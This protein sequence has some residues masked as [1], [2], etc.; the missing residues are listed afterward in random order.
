MLIETHCH[1]DYLKAEPLEDLL[2]KAQQSQI[3]KIITIGVAPENLDTARD[4]ALKYEQVYYTQ[5]IHPHDAKDATEVEFG[6]IAIRSL[7][8][9]MVAI[10]EIGT[11]YHY[12]NSPAD[13]QRKVF[14]KQLQLAVIMIYPS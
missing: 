2:L 9:K 10:G 6:K 5:G 3:T 8:K 14:E 4:I 11:D 1:L 12:N 7:E 13:V